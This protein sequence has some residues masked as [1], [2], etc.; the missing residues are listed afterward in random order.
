M[1]WLLLWFAVSLSP[2]GESPTRDD[3]DDEEEKDDREEA[4]DAAAVGV[5]TGAAVGVAEVGR[6]AACK[7]GG[8][9]GEA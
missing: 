4:Q 8:S 5:G 9:G 2:S 1:G 7:D 3:D 6:C